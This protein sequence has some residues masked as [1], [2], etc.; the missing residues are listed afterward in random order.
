MH[1]IHHQYGR[2]RNNYGDITWW[3]MLFGTYEN[4]REF[5]GRCGFDIDKELQLGNM[6]MW[7]DVHRDAPPA[8]GVIDAQ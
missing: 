8:I 5:N 3:D 6:L 2:H 4:P 7:R 1:R